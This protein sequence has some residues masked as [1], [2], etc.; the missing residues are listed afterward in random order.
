M[1]DEYTVTTA[2]HGRSTFPRTLLIGAGAF[3]AVIAIVLVCGLLV[4]DRAYADRVYPGVHVLDLNLGGLTREQAEG[5]LSDRLKTFSASPVTLTFQG[6]DWRPAAEQLGVQV[7]LKATVGE[8]MDVGRQGNFLTG[9]AEKIA[10]WRSARTV[11]LSVR[12]DP[13]KLEQYLQSVASEVDKPTIEGTA[14]LEGTQVKTKPAQAGQQL[15]ATAAVEAIKLSLS[16]LSIDKIPLTVK[17]TNPTINEDEV[18]RVS[19]VLSTTVATP[20][21]LS[22]NDRDWILQPSEI[23]PLLQVNEQS[24]GDGSKR[25]AVGVNQAK[26]AELAAS[27]AK[28]INRE[29]KNAKFDWANDS[30]QTISESQDGWTL[31][32]KAFLGAFSKQLTTD[33]RAMALPVTVTKP[34]VSSADLGA[35]G[36][37]ELVAEGKSSFQGS[38]EARATNVKVASSYLNGAVIAPGDIFSFN[39]AIGPITKEAGYV[40]GLT[41]AADATVPDIGGGVCQL[42]TTTFRAAFWAGLPITE[43]NQ[44]AYRVSW[45]EAMGEPVGFDAAIYQPYADLK[46]KNN[47]SAYMLIETSISDDSTLTVSFYGTKPGWEVEMEKPV[48]GEPV[49]HPDD[50]Y[51]TDPTLPKGT[52]KQV[53]WAVDGID[54]TITRKIT[55]DGEV[56]RTDDFFSSYKPWANKY[57][58]NE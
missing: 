51:Q 54:V 22:F 38:S 15:D 31:D 45:Y 12:L 52:K 46:F 2:A 32:E 7:D 36:I 16:T 55:Q 34:K 4:F 8:A 26:V 14:W 17:T 24:A 49:P 6:R 37:V 29:T 41:I 3:V 28:D 18:T 53:E 9:A 57:L 13:P 21:K 19:A 58:V 10:I 25:L 11:P 47:T 1:S 27:L 43:R 30:L 23:A 40:E 5:A 48:I 39:D 50:V 20:F 56:I 44:H 42:A 33:Q 35:L